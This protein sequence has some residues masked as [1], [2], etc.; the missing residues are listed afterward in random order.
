VAA[1]LTVRFIDCVFEAI[2]ASDAL[3]PLPWRRTTLDDRRELLDVRSAAVCLLRDLSLGRPAH[4]A[5][6]ERLLAD[7]V[8]GDYLRERKLLI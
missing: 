4:P 2:Y 7:E 1:R 6:V 3:E 5:L 8:I